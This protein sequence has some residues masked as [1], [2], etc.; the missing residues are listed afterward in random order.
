MTDLLPKKPPTLAKIW[1]VVLLIYYCIF[2]RSDNYGIIIY[3]KSKS[4]PQIILNLHCLYLNF[5]VLSLI[6][7]NERIDYPIS[8]LSLLNHSLIRIIKPINPKFIIKALFMNKAL[9]I[10]FGK[11]TNQRALINFYMS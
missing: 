3:I 6:N 9:I 4:L 11:S 1:L 7:H 10:H 8:E 2:S 5:N